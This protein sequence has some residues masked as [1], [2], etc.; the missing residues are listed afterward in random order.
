ML[1][2]LDTRHRARAAGAPDA[3]P[4]RVAG[5]TPGGP[6]SSLAALVYAGRLAQQMVARRI[7]IDPDTGRGW[8]LWQT[9]APRLH[10]RVGALVLI[11]QGG[12]LRA[13]DVYTGEPR[14]DFA[15]A[16]AR[17]WEMVRLSDGAILI[18]LFDGSWLE[19]EPDSGRVRAEG[20]KRRAL[21]SEL[22]RGA[23]RLLDPLQRPRAEL[24]V[25]GHAVSFGGAFEVRPLADVPPSDDGAV[26]AGRRTIRRWAALG[27]TPLVQT[28]PRRVLAMLGRGA[29]IGCAAIDLATLDLVGPVALGS[30]AE[31]PAL[32]SLRLLDGV[33]VA[34][35]RLPAALAHEEG[36]AI[37]LVVH[38]DAELLARV[39]VGG[40]ETF[41]AGRPAWRAR[42]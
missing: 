21:A 1:L 42:I 9:L 39:A 40:F 2:A 27:D 11:E 5:A 33:A 24:V 25:A 19:L 22:V 14:W 35:L 20:G 23:A 4:Y 10:G 16:K 13:L 30:F 31:P 6:G 8:M 34:R 38:P 26:M 29:E 37:V 12:R 28:G 3:S 18:W 17:I 41:E 7:E 36:E 15:G 32:E